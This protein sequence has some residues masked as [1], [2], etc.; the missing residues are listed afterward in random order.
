R[1]RRHRRRGNHPGAA[2][3]RAGVGEGEQLLGHGAGRSS[4]DGQ[5]VANGL[6]RDGPS[7]GATPCPTT[8]S[9]SSPPA[10]CK[11]RPS[12]HH[13]HASS[14]PLQANQHSLCSTLPHT[15]GWAPW[16]PKSRAQTK[17]NHVGPANSQTLTFDPQP[18]IFC[19]FGSAQ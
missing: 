8:D 11:L 13:A 19:F 1:G 4:A 12:P 10:P 6:K 18:I 14:A 7:L 2:G 15:I 5:R 3:Q 9:T 17:A 16:Y